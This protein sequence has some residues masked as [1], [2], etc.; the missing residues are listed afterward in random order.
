M[1]IKVFVMADVSESVWCKKKIVQIFCCVAADAGSPP[2][3][4]CY[5]RTADLKQSKSTFGRTADRSQA[6]RSVA[7][8]SQERDSTHLHGP[9]TGQ[10]HCAAFLLADAGF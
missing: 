8:D 4:P 5:G 1:A 7:V 10:P 2:H 3:Y 9:S 6:D